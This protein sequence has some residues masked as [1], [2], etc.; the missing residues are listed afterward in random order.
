MGLREATSDLQMNKKRTNKIGKVRTEARGL[1]KKF[2]RR[3]E[4]KKMDLNN[5]KMKVQKLVLVRMYE[6]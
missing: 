2:N 6:A 3:I 1:N 5:F 4:G